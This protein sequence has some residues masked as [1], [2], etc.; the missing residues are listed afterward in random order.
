MKNEK[1]KRVAALALAGTIAVSTISPAAFAAGENEEGENQAV[2]SVLGDE[3][4]G[5]SE[6]TA[7]KNAET[8]A[9]NEEKGE[10]ND[11]T[12]SDN[13]STAKDNSTVVDNNPALS[14]DD[15]VQ[16]TPIEPP[17]IEELPELPA[18]PENPT[19]T[20][21]G[22]YNEAVTDYNDDVNDYNNEVGV[23]TTTGE[24]EEQKTTYPE[25]SY[26]DA[27]QDYN[28]A[29]EE[30]NDALDDKLFGTE[31]SEGEEGEG[32]SEG[33]TGLLEGN[34]TIAGT[35]SVPAPETE[36]KKPATGNEAD[37]E[38]NESL[39]TGTTV[40]DTE[41]E[42]SEDLAADRA[43]L[44]TAKR[45]LE[46]AQ[47]EL[48]E[49][50]NSAD[51]ETMS[52]EDKNALL[53]AYQDKVNSYNQAVDAYNHKTDGTGTLD[54][55]EEAINNYNE[56]TLTENKETADGNT[57]AQTSNDAAFADEDL[58]EYLEDVSAQLDAL[59]GVTVPSI[60]AALSSAGVTFGEGQSMED[61]SAE[62]QA[63]VIAAYNKLVADYNQAVADYN[64]KE[65]PEDA[66]TIIQQTYQDAL[67]EYNAAVK[68]KLEG[69]M[70]TDTAGSDIENEAG[71]TNAEVDTAN[72]DILDPEKEGSNAD[73]FK[74]VNAGDEN[75]GTDLE[76]NMPTLEAALEA[77]K[78]AAL[79]KAAAEAGTTVAEL[80][81][82]T[83][84]KIAA[85]YDDADK[86][87]A[88]NQAAVVDA[89]NALV[90]EYNAKVSEYNDGKDTNGD[91]VNEI[92][93]AQE[94]YDQ[95]W[96]EYNQ[97]KI[98]ETY[99]TPKDETDP[100]NVKPATGNVADLAANE[101]ALAE[102]KAT[103]DQIRAY[104]DEGKLTTI[105]QEQLNAAYAALE[106]EQT[107]LDG[108][109]AAKPVL[110]GLDL[111][112]ENLNTEF[113]ALINDYNNAVDSY[114]KLVTDHN[115]GTSENKGI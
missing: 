78:N 5:G 54:Q 15:G 47:Q 66:L 98:D 62:D 112:S 30:H 58:K 42:D 56:D 103:L 21:I 114:N 41:I 10:K 16:L 52:A 61:L 27:V 59:D 80:D 70:G 100:D 75:P 34:A 101:A 84:A 109:Y 28:T 8:E 111:D 49:A 115:N 35:P 9:K 32:G 104:I 88:E 26:N 93:S 69:Q 107:A 6:S 25:G 94:A 23:P 12:I 29:A 50:K 99:G 60:D 18:L 36:E 51:W 85:Q 89:F 39:M 87:T 110:D 90:D 113:E 55:Y 13:S 82:E 57:N 24:G 86:L 81:E 65:D 76:L 79:E 63:K 106:A 45:E 64:A 3:E 33:T 91:G 96:K 46:E 14:G 83:Q 43:E 7:S 68:E 1:M 71:E 53:Q 95:A 72:Q 105:T 17:T 40:N 2:P 11:D 37:L 108:A 73:A 102:A 92:L 77:A 48:E 22:D 31:G 97:Q 20:D 74:D 67:D 19:N 38:S 4:E 44:D